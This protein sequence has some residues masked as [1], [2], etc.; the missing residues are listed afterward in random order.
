MMLAFPGCT[1][2]AS[3]CVINSKELNLSGPQE[4]NLSRPNLLINIQIYLT[5]E[6]ASEDVAFSFIKEHLN[7]PLKRLTADS[8]SASMKSPPST[9]ILSITSEIQT[10]IVCG[11][12]SVSGRMT[13]CKNRSYHGFG[14]NYF[15][16]V[17]DRSLVKCKH[18]TNLKHAEV[19]FVMDS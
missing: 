3:K 19:S 10:L 2:K 4:M 13:I 12:L 7:F 5:I 18:L 16:L 8:I 15:E 14:R 17:A 9:G 6:R 11:L 1:R